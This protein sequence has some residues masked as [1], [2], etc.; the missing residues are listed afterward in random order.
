M[1]IPG[2]SLKRKSVLDKDKDVVDPSLINNANIVSNTIE[3]TDELNYDEEFSMNNIT[4]YDKVKYLIK[5]KIDV[6]N[7]INLMKKEERKSHLEKFVLFNNYFD[8]GL[9]SFG[10]KELDGANK[11]LTSTEDVINLKQQM[12]MNIILSIIT[13]ELQELFILQQEYLKKQSIED[14]F[15]KDFDFYRE[16]MFFCVCV[17]DKIK[18][19]QNNFGTFEK[20]DIFIILENVKQNNVD[21]IAAITAA[22]GKQPIINIV[23]PPGYNMN[24]AP[25]MKKWGENFKIF[26]QKSNSNISNIKNR[27]LSI[28]RSKPIT[29]TTP[30]STND[31]MKKLFVDFMYILYLYEFKIDKFPLTINVNNPGDS[32]SLQEYFEKVVNQQRNYYDQKFDYI[33]KVEYLKAEESSK[34]DE[35]LSAQNVN[36]L[37]DNVDI[38]RANLEKL[39]KRGG[40]Q[41]K[42]N[43]N[44]TNRKH[45]TTRKH[46]K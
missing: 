45:K 22:T 29:T 30:E 40:V 21:F 7:L 33:I 38:A 27:F 17:Y 4:Q 16:W 10:L 36:R 3:Y 5:K 24:I 31:C 32:T 9:M 43:K 26:Q 19:A 20:N 8:R 2:S 35:L 41:I 46:K 15:Y 23:D 6:Y 12:K 13:I 28:F 39:P 11:I 25:L 44:K 37:Q 18:I 42:T 14:S 1:S 34:Q